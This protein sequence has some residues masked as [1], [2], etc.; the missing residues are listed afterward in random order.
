MSI[1]NRDSRR[2]AE[3]CLPFKA[4]NIFGEYNR[5][6]V[7]VVYS[8]GYHYPMFAYLNGTWYENSDK[9]SVTTSKHHGQARP[10]GDTVKV[11]TEDLQ[12]LIRG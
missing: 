10:A 2:F 6:G 5:E 12:R 7:Y 8:Y 1:T 4:N 9:Y 11:N 3:Q